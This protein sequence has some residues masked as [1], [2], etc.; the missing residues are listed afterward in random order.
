MHPDGRGASLPF[1]SSTTDLDK[2][3]TVYY[4]LS[5]PNTRKVPL[6]RH[7]LRAD[8]GIRTSDPHLGK[9]MDLVR[10]FGCPPLSG[11]FSAGLSP[12]SAESARL[13]WRT[14]NELNLYHLE[15]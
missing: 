8:D 1:R 12:Q 9:V 7:F 5:A 4:L 14:L 11:V 3:R 10:R 13:R 6:T 2:R 15:R